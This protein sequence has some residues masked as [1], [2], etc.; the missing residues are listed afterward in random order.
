MRLVGFYAD[1]RIRRS[2]LL[3]PAREI[4]HVRTSDNMGLD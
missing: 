1:G 3:T 4:A 2:R